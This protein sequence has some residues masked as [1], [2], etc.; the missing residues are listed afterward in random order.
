MLVGGKRQACD[1]LLA[2]VPYRRAVM[3]E[4]DARWCGL[5][6]AAESPVLPVGDHSAAINCGC[7]GDMFSCVQ[8]AFVRR[9]TQAWRVG[10]MR[11]E[12]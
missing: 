12:V 11:G 3:Q 2:S 8:R 5:P 9:R 6:V 10:T 7:P 1:G 4:Q